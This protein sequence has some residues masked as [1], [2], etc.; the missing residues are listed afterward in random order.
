MAGGRVMPEHPIV[1]CGA[2]ATKACGG[3][4]TNEILPDALELKQELEREGFLDLLERFL[5]E[6]RKDYRNPHIA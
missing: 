2:G 5:M 6:N 1:I 3:P 4:L